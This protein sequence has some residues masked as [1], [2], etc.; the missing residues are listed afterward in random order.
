VGRPY[1]VTIG[2]T[3]RTPNCAIISTK[4]SANRTG[5]LATAIRLLRT[6]VLPR[7]LGGATKRSSTANQTRPSD[8]RIVA[9][10]Q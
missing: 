10:V 3:V 8:S 5:V 2:C 9:E 7:P 6:D 4:N 1:K